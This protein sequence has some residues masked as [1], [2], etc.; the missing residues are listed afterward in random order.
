MNDEAPK[1]KLS[2]PFTKM[3]VQLDHN[4]AADFGGAF[5]VIP[6]VGGGDPVQGC[7][8]TSADPVQFW[9]LLQSQINKSLEA[10]KAGPQQF[11]MPRR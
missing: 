3:A 8:L 9:L 1:A 11:G 5:V 4:D 6:P 2:E 7:L 10:A